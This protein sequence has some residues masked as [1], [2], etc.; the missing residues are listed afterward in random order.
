MIVSDPKTDRLGQAR[1]NVV[2]VMVP[3]GYAVG[4]LEDAAGRL[5]VTVK[6]P[7]EPVWPAGYEPAEAMVVAPDELAAQVFATSE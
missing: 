6:A 2:N 1:W 3:P 7:A 5:T 4:I